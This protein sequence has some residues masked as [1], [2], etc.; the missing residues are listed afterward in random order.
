MTEQPTPDAIMQIGL[1][2]WAS[3]T[4]LSA[5]EIGLFTAL[6][7]KSL[8]ADD[9]AERLGLHARS[10]RVTRVATAAFRTCGSGRCGTSRISTSS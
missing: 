9:V 8:T 3:K 1:G 5:V 2:F 10:R 6:A 4:F 7:D